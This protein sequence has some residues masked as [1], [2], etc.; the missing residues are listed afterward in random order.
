MFGLNDR[1][2]LNALEQE[3]EKKLLNSTVALQSAIRAKKAKLV[4]I[5][6]KEEDRKRK[7]EEQR[8]KE[9]AS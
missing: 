3:R 8:R 9:L 2:Q 6:L 4:Y 7:E 5:R 1:L